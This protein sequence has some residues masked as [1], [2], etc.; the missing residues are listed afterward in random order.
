MQIILHDE[1]VSNKKI[2]PSYGDFQS[3]ALGIKE[4]VNVF[5][6][7][8]HLPSLRLLLDYSK[9]SSCWVEGLKRV[10]RWIFEHSKLNYCH[11]LRNQGLSHYHYQNQIFMKVMMCMNAAY[12]KDY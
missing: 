1:P 4:N 10:T 9:E 3:S 8:H 7:N 6:L 5:I 2:S 11:M 12:G